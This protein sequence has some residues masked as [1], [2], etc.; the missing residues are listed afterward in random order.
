MEDGRMENRKVEIKVV[1]VVESSS[2]PGVKYEIRLGHDHRLYCTC[3]GWKFG[4]RTCKHLR[5]FEAEVAR[6]VV[7]L[8]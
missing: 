1:R 8:G 2:R 5:A 4:G 6:P 3:P 7:V